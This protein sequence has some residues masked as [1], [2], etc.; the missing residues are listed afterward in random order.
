[1][2]ERLRGAIAFLMR[3]IKTLSFQLHPDQPISPQARQIAQCAFEQAIELFRVHESFI[4][5]YIEFLLGELIPTSSYQRHIT[6]LRA[7]SLL[8]KSGILTHS[9]EAP[10]LRNQEN[11]TVWPCMIDFFNQISTK[12]L[13]DLLMDPFQD[14]R[15]SATSILKLASPDNFTVGK[16]SEI[17]PA[18]AHALE[19]NISAKII[20][21]ADQISFGSILSGSHEAESSHLRKNKTLTMLRDF[22][23]R[24][25]EFSKRTGRADYADG[26]ARSYE[27]LYGLLSSASERTQ[28]LTQLVE[29]L[30]T[31]VSIAE[32]NLAK[33][34]LDEPVHGTFAA[35]K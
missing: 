34:V 28:L 12:L 14:V 15:S 1:M 10:K 4:E 23:K 3:E 35:L 33:A 16:L 19:P 11:S 2:T 31:K 32:Q 29:D 24:A 25:E 8:L 18:D 30:E 26:V 6:S 13:L 22:I 5:W 27:L 7:I 21:A 20:M 17:S 9:S